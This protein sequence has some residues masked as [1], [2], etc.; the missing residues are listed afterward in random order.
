LPGGKK[1]RTVRNT[2][3]VFDEADREIDAADGFDQ[4]G[5]EFIAASALL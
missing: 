4:P 5:P 1:R 2:G 3:W